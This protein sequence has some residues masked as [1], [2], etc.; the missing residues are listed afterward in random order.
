METTMTDAPG[1]VRPAPME[2]GGAYNR[3][4]RVQASGLL[5][6]VSLLDEAARVVPVPAPP[7]VPLIADYGASE[8]RN[9]LAPIAVALARLHERIGKE[10]A[11]FVVHADLP[12]NDFSALFETLAASPD[13][14]LRGDAAAFPVAVGRSHFEQILPA[15]SV[16]LGWS[17]WAIQWLSRVPAPIPD[18]VQ[19]AYSKDPAARLAYA[20][21]AAD[22]WTTFLAMR[23]RELCP[24]GRIV[25]V[26]MA[27]DDRGDFGYRPVMDAIVGA[28][29]ELVTAGVIGADELRDMVIPTFART[30][31]QFAEPFAASGR[32]EGLS[33]T[34]LDVFHGD[35]RIW[36]QFQADGDARAFGAQWAAFSR[37]SVFPTLAGALTGGA[38]EARRATF[39]D[40]L[41]SAMAAHL[42]SAPQA[43]SIPL[44]RMVIARD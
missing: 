38:S 36:K 41:E 30:R 24:G 31:A 14:Y 19:A 28:L 10:R 22:D 3:S 6:A 34:D 2:S 32:F 26:T 18:H 15:G 25:V 23:S 35:D 33:L 44:A 8:G 20:R 7:H 4:S 13:S 40:R 16:S 5:P 37:A 17:S 43:V 12:G 27:T 21:Q 39:M 1:S 29:H 42:A 9:S 11:V